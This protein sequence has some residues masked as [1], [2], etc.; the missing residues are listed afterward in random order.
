MKHAIL[1]VAG[2]FGSG[3]TTAVR[4]FHANYPTEEMTDLNSNKALGYRTEV[5]VLGVPLFTIGSYRN[6]C[7]G[8]DAIPTQEDAGTRILKAHTFGHV[9]Y[10]GALVSASG[11]NGTVCRM[12]EP[13]GCTIYA[14]LDTPMEK[15]IE[16][17]KARRAA[18]GNEK[19]FDPDNL[20]KK[21]DSV[22]STY[23]A[24]KKNGNRVHLI[25]HENIHDALLNILLEFGHGKT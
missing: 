21:F 7:G 15:C 10:E 5:P 18:K 13:T 20:V 22:V 11:L 6:V 2:T 17:V 24:L 12:T 1:R 23:K 19:E 16:R 8:C 14:F 3:K 4:D 25:D 9:L